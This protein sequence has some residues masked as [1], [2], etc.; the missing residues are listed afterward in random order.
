MVSAVLKAIKILCSFSEWEE[1]DVI[2]LYQ[3]NIFRKDTCTPMFTAAMFT[4]DRIWKQPRCPST[5]EWIKKVWYSEILLSHKKEYVLMN[6][7]ICSN[8]VDETRAHY[9][10]WIKSE[11]EIQILYTH[12]HTH[13]HI[14]NLR[15]GTDKFIFR[16]AV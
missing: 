1:L 3:K 15:D 16:A 14:W 5:D 13:T 6:I 9:T 2:L 7:W 10:E 11:R 8:E 12:I 4:I